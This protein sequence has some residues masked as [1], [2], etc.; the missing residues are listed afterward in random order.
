MLWGS[1]WAIKLT[2]D[3]GS[4]LLDGHAVEQGSSPPPFRDS[5]PA[6]SRSP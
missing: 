5:E 4:G 3:P 2:V 6:S 1:L